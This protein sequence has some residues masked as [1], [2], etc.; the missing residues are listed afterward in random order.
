MKCNVNFRTEYAIVNGVEIHIGDYIEGTTPMCI[1]NHHELVAV[2]GD[3][4]KHHFRHKHSYDVCHSPLSEWHAEWQ[5]HFKY[6][7]IEFPL[8]EGQYKSRRADIVIGDF[9]ID[10]QHTPHTVV[11][12]QHSP[13]TLEE[14]CQRNHDY[15]L[16]HKK[17]IWI[18]DGTGVN[19]TNNILL[20]EKDFWKFDSFPPDV[21]V[22]IDINRVIYT[23]HP[24]DVKSCSVHVPE[25]IPKIIFIQSLK[26]GHDI[27]NLPCSQNKL[28][29]KQQGAGNGKTYGIIQMLSRKEFSHYTRFIYV[30][31]Q[32]S[33]RSIIHE[34]FISQKDSLGI[35][36]LNEKDSS[37]KYI[38]QY[39]NGI[40]INC[41]IIISTI[42]SFMYSLGEKQPKT[43][44]LFEGIVRSIYEKNI[45]NETVE[46]NGKI[47]YANL[48]KL[49]AHT[50]YVVDEAQDLHESYADALCAI[51]KH[52]NMDVYVVGDKLQSI[53][54]EENT[55]TKL[56]KCENAI[57]ETPINCCRRFIH[58]KL[59]D[60][61]ND[62]IPFKNFNLLPIT[63]WTDYSGKEYEPLELFPIL[64]Y[65][66]DFKKTNIEECVK[67]FMWRFEKEVIENDRCPEDF[68]IVTPWVNSGSSVEL[69][70][71]L[72]LAIQE[73][74]VNQLQKREFTSK[75]SPY[76][77]THDVDTFTNYSVLHRTVEGTCINLD[78][79]K[80]A[81]RIVSIHASKGDGRKVVFLIDPSLFKLSVFSMK[82][83]LKFY[84]TLHVSLTRMKEKLY[85]MHDDDEVGKN[86]KNAMCKTN[87]PFITNT[88][89]ISSSTSY[90]EI[91]TFMTSET[92]LFKTYQDVVYVDDS[93]P[94]KIIDSSHHNIRFCIMLAKT[95]DILKD[96]DQL[97]QIATVVG[98]AMGNRTCIPWKT[99][100]EYNE[101]L[102]KNYV[103]C[104]HITCMNRREEGKYCF[105]HT[106]ENPKKYNRNIPLLELNTREHRQYVSILH[107][108]MKKIKY[109][110][111]AQLSLCPFELIVQ[112]YMVN[113]VDRGQYTGITMNELYNMID[114]YSKSFK[115]YMKGHDTCLCKKLFPHHEH[116][117]TLSDYLCSHYEK[118][119]AY[120]QTVQK[121]KDTYGLLSWNIN[122]PVHMTGKHFCINTKFDL[123]GYTSSKVIILYLTPNL[124]NLNFNDMK[125]RAAV[126]RFIVQN[127]SSKDDTR[128]ANKEVVCCILSLNQMNPYILPL[129]DSPDMKNH[130]GEL[131]KQK[132]ERKHNEVKAFYDY[133][134]YKGNSIDTVVEEYEKCNK[135]IQDIQDKC[136]CYVTSVLLHIQSSYNNC[137]DGVN[138]VTPEEYIRK[139]SSSGRGN[140]LHLL[141]AKLERCLKE[142]GFM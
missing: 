7:E 88:L 13:I 85:I 5:S 106:K 72:D 124:T 33:A 86:L 24:S 129:Q 26:D 84:S 61:V 3:Y 2:K 12:V 65:S 9:V 43:L 45:M 119:E 66:N 95:Y 74:W 29:I 50:L 97:T 49:N 108:T 81:T 6:T 126:D 42:D 136:V 58:P 17:V 48:P 115:H 107:Q 103:K 137:V 39:T 34:E 92:G 62:M 118:M 125:Y 11:E 71:H 120:E 78:E 59:V 55:F 90:K 113:V 94:S 116:K 30:T 76:W 54:F 21:Y 132:Y 114:I 23:F 14:V 27:F 25:G 20:F 22:F 101:D 40:G 15:Q 57:L 4:N 19:I 36:I 53:H 127:C 122:H 16:H 142:D 64:K 44:D 83:S 68:L 1:S 121:L 41:S 93:E 138:E 109:N 82:D 141:Q 8:V 51:M 32:H 35:T 140:L 28:Y 79:S 104:S 139:I 131:L 100:N 133:W 67:S 60:F 56:M 102:K 112:L 37:K 117:N 80:Y 70:N 52:T 135:Y 73:F 123:I 75:L 130:I 96:G 87:C 98:Y 134:M 10:F 69:I 77:N 46:K 31:K 18:I 91:S 110:F 99:W 47:S 111:T 128:Y 38:I 63:S 105:Q 89:H